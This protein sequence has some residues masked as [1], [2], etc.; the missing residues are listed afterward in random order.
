MAVE[1]HL[2]SHAMVVGERVEVVH[3]LEA[4]AVLAA[5]VL[6]VVHRREVHQHVEAQVGVV[7][8]KTQGARQR[9]PLHH[10]GVVTALR[11]RLDDA[12]AEARA[13]AL[14]DRAAVHAQYLWAPTA[15]LS[16]S[17]ISPSITDSGR[18]GQPG[19]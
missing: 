10:R 18:G 4:R 5:R 7:A 6:L 13:Q 8:A 3:D 1:A 11:V 17:F 15:I 9:R 12:G 2:D 19:M 14:E 16:W